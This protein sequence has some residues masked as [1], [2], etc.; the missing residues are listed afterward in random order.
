MSNEEE[1]R[2][3]KRLS[4]K[5]LYL[6]PPFGKEKIGT[7]IYIYSREEW[8]IIEDLA[9]EKR[10]GSPRKVFEKENITVKK[11]YSQ[12]IKGLHHFYKAQQRIETLRRYLFLSKKSFSSQAFV[13]RA[14]EKCILYTISG[15]YEFSQGVAYSPVN[16]RV[17]DQMINLAKEIRRLS[18]KDSFEN[19]FSKLIHLFDFVVENSYK[20]YPRNLSGDIS[21]NKISYDKEIQNFRTKVL[22]D[23]ISGVLKK[24]AEKHSI[25]VSRTEKD[26]YFLFDFRNYEI[27]N[28]LITYY[29][30]KHHRRLRMFSK[31]WFEKLYL[32]FPVGPIYFFDLHDGTQKTLM[33]YFD[34]ARFIIETYFAFPQVRSPKN[35]K[36]LT[37][38]KR[39]QD[40]ML[41]RIKFLEDQSELQEDSEKII[42]EPPSQDEINWEIVTEYERFHTLKEISLILREKLYASFFHNCLDP[43]HIEKLP[44]N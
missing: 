26:D 28:N 12:F 35:F 43:Q 13:E 37:G 6:M 4:N 42:R 1:Y 17:S 36:D 18:A 21:E 3:L 34:R 14:I 20:F 16:R 24:E 29:R 2:F 5:I 31:A 27:S 19:I 7:H 44:V 15:Y 33:G 9:L 32:N 22:V 40:R 23:E 8:T 10:V 25:L 11:K 30:N 41:Q 39:I 38:F